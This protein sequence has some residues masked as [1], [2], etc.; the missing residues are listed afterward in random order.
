M[1]FAACLLTVV[2][3]AVFLMCFGF[4]SREDLLLIAGVNIIT[5]LLLNLALMLIYHT[6]GL[7]PVC[8]F[9]IIAAAAEYLLYSAAYGGSPRLFCLTLCANLLSFCLGLLV[10]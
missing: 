10:F 4:R 6:T 7:W 2:T 8:P 1:I 9:E 3:E 5:N